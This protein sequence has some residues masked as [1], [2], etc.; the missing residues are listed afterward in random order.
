MAIERAV[1]RQLV[2]RLGRIVNRVDRI[3]DDLRQAPDRD[4]QEAAAEAE[5]DEVLEGLDEMSRAE[6]GEIRA[7][8]RRMDSGQY[9]FCVECGKAIPPER[10]AAVPTASK[11]IWCA[12]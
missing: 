1:R 9:G 3:E 8:L 7:A 11:C 10:L 12:A 5:N 6:V 2:E 4:W